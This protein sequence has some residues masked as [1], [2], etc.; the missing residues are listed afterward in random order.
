MKWEAVKRD[1]RALQEKVQARRG[2]KIAGYNARRV[3]AKPGRGFLSRTVQPVFR[4][5]KPARRV[6]R[7]R[8]SISSRLPYTSSSSTKARNDFDG[9][10]RISKRE[11]PERAQDGAGTEAS[12]RDSLASNGR[13]VSICHHRA[14]SRQLPDPSLVS[15]PPRKSTA[16]PKPFSAK[17][18]AKKMLGAGRKRSYAEAEK[19]RPRART[20]VSDERGRT[21]VGLFVRN[22]QGRKGKKNK[23]RR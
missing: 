10:A 4:T 12:A 1:G 6:T 22:S 20:L 3:E 16:R 9:R 23:S 17:W 15:G 21:N 2:R 11:V 18:E 7:T 5:R 8:S 14:P 19:S 13:S